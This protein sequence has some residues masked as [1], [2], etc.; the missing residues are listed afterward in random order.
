MRLSFYDSI[1]KSNNECTRF[2]SL[3][4]KS[5]RSAIAENRRMLLSNFN[6]REL[7]EIETPLL[8]KYFRCNG[9]C[10]NEG[11]MLKELFLIRDKRLFIDFDV[12]K[13]HLLIDLIS[14]G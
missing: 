4:C 2:C 13:I 11:G 7:C 12:R 9:I 5:S 3:L 10:Q 6:K 1:S 14:T 8:Q